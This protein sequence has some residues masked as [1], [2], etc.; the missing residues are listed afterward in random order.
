MSK[1]SDNPFA[2]LAVAPVI[3]ASGK[4]TA[5]GGTAQSPA[6]SRA[7]AKAA[8]QHV[9]LT[10]LRRAA[11]GRVAELSGAEDACITTGAAAG[12]CIAT[13]AVIAG[14]DPDAIAAMPEV[15][16]GPAEIVLQ[17]GHDINFGAPVVKMIRLGGGRPCV[18]GNLAGVSGDEVL[19]AMTDQTAA[20]L[21][22]KSHHCVQEGRVSLADFLTLAHGKGLPVIVDAAAEEDLEKYISLGADLVTY[23]GGKAIGGPTVGFIV[24]RRDLI[25]ACEMMGSGIARAMKVGKEQIMGLMA[26]LD[27]FGTPHTWPARLEL[28]LELLAGL[29]GI[30]VSRVADRAGRNIERV[31]I[32]ASSEAFNVTDLMIYLREGRP[33]I[34]TRNHQLGEGL[35]LL[36]PRELNQDQVR[37]VTSRIRAFTESRGANNQDPSR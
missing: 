25:E 16:D 27:E 29:P 1:D 19:G 12:I 35:L 11:A 23:S 28:L 34:R 31:C 32:R 21:F 30:E 13:A 6:V 22:V 26:A 37:V 10:E 33:S 14:T 17:S 15:S 2:T 5:L 4:M 36:D 18:V 20:A 24:G 3:N 9:D 8:T 7:Q